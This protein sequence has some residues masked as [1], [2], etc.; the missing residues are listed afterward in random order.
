MSTMRAPDII[1]VNFNSG[2]DSSDDEVVDDLPQ[3]QQQLSEPADTDTCT[4]EKS[5][6]SLPQADASYVLCVRFID[7]RRDTLNRVYGI[8]FDRTINSRIR[9]IT[10]AV[11]TSSSSSPSSSSSSATSPSVPTQGKRHFRSVLYLD[12]PSIKQC[13]HANVVPQLP[14]LIVLELPNNDSAA[15]YRA[16]VSALLKSQYIDATLACANSTYKVAILIIT[17]RNLLSAYWAVAQ[18]N[19]VIMP[20][21]RRTS[22]TIA[23]VSP[24]IPPVRIVIYSVHERNLDA[25]SSVVQWLL[26]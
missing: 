15:D 4:Q 16:N 22:I 5:S 25:V 26:T 7:S 10:P 8:D 12:Q 11:T 23:D 14:Q 6:Q 13:L 9:S 21:R 2:D 24:S 3:Q 1:V 19:Q 17:S 18:F 20:L